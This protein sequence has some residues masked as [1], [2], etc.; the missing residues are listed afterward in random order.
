MRK[1]YV[2]DRPSIDIPRTRISLNCPH[3]VSQLSFFRPRADRSVRFISLDRCHFRSTLTCKKVIARANFRQ[4]ALR[5]RLRHCNR[6]SPISSIRGDVV[7]FFLRKRA[8]RE[9]YLSRSEFPELKLR[10]ANEM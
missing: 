7:L 5:T 3:N 9:L 8:G 2:Q 10:I 6:S 4:V 1:K